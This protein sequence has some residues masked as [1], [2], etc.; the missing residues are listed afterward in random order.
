MNLLKVVRACGIAVHPHCA[1]S[2]RIWQPG[3][4]VLGQVLAGQ[5]VDLLK[6]VGEELLIWCPFSL[7][8]IR[9]CLVALQIEV[10]AAGHAPR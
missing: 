1:V 10:L 3:V 8:Y 6:V 7:C 5:H 9:A 2:E 4:W